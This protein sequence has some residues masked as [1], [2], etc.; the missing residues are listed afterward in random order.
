M[1]GPR[2]VFNAYELFLL[3][4]GG[5]KRPGR[6]VHAR[7]SSA[8]VKNEW[9]YTSASPVYIRG[10]DRDNFTFLGFYL[11]TLSVPQIIVSANWLEYD[12]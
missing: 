11:V 1:D 6:D 9:S 7:P 5:V 3:G 4:L 2:F 8:R 12:E 10:V